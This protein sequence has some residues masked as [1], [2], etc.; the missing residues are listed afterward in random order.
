MFFGQLHDT[1][2]PTLREVS[3]VLQCKGMVLRMETSCLEQLLRT[4]GFHFAMRKEEAQNPEVRCKV[5]ANTTRIP[6]TCQSLSSHIWC[7][8]CPSSAKLSLR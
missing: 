4:D 7:S 8:I 6:L 1:P 3:A 5:V 2:T